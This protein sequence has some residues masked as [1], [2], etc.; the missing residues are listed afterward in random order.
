MEILNGLLNG[1]KIISGQIELVMGIIV[2]IGLLLQKAKPIDVVIGVVKAVLGVMIL[3]QGST[4]LQGAYRP[5]M[6]ML[7]AT[8]NISGVVTENYSSIAAVNV[9]LPELVGAAPTIMV[10][11]FLLNL[12]LV[13]FGPLK[14]V[15][16]TAHTMF[17]LS[18][19]TV[20][21]MNWFF[22]LTGIKL[23]LIGALFMGLFMTIMPSWSYKYSKPFIGN[24][25]AIGHVSCTASIISSNIGRMFSKW[26]KKN[27]KFFDETEADE[28]ASSKFSTLNRLFSDSTVVTF[29]LMTVV[30][31]LGAFLAGK[32]Q[33]L[34]YAGNTNWII[35][36]LELGGGFTLGIFILMTGVRMMIAELV[37][38]FRGIA[39]KIVPGAVPAVDM[40]VVL[41][42]APF[43]AVLGFIGAFLGEFI[44]FFILLALGS[45]ILLIPGIIATFFDGGVAGVFGFKYGG[46]KSAFISGLVV[47]LVQI[48][49]GLFFARWTGFDQ[50][51]A[52]WGNTDFG[53]TMMALAGIMKVLPSEWLFVAVMIGLYVLACFRLKHLF[54]VSEEDHAQTE[55]V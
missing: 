25:Y 50:L 18:V 21:L 55:S 19:L 7:R 41:P 35:Y 16:L 30:L 11:G 40:A 8:F 2:L 28:T 51:G 20:W 42:L 17:G 6:E 13:K 36:A 34:T 27:P 47:G 26:D 54:V 38:A 43:A 48:L 32:E 14:T 49:G 53:S 37:P 29:L 31:G 46:R 39:E 24:S 3:K 44:G 5:V 12:L 1:F 22:G 15:W 33:I 4:L 23:I 52:T 45:P 10:L 9:A